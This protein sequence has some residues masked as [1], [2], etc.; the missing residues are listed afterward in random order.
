MHTS[1]KQ[2]VAVKFHLSEEQ[3]CINIEQVMYDEYGNGNLGSIFQ[4]M[5][6]LW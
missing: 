5:D 2:L 4:I 1:N 6:D 3:Y